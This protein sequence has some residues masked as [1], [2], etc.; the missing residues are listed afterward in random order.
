MPGRWNQRWYQFISANPDASSKDIYQFAGKMLDE[1][2]LNN[3]I[4]HGYRK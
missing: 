3:V 1:Y 2:N 4:I